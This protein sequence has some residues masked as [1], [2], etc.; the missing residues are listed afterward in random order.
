[1][2][3]KSLFTGAGIFSVLLSILGI[4]VM[5]GAVQLGIG[6]L[7]QPGAGL[8]PFVTGVI[9][10]ASAIVV[11]ATELDGKNEVTA[12][13]LDK[14][15]CRTLAVVI[16]SMAG[17]IVL[18]PFLGYIVVSFAAV[19]ALAKVLGVKGSLQPL[20]LSAGTSL[21]IY[22]LFDRLL[23]LDLPRGWFGQG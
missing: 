19:F 14:N 12:L 22:V 13:S 4:A 8:F 21:A 6:G 23:Y 3:R 20:I 2:N 1:M 11:I 16:M 7:Q 18:M 5:A 10:A 15:G 9:I 17:W